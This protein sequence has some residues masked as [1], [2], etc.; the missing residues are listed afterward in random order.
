MSTRP[1]SVGVDMASM[2]MLQADPETLDVVVAQPIPW[3]RTSKDGGA[4]FLSTNG[5][6]RSRATP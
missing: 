6:G 2:R 4:S 3:R 1:G 5:I